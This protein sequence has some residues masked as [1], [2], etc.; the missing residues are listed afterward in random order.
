MN[1]VEEYEGSTGNKFDLVMRVRDDGFA[2][3]DWVL[4]ANY[5]HGFTTLDCQQWTGLHDMSY[6]MGRTFASDVLHSMIRWR[7]NSTLL[8]DNL[9]QE[10]RYPQN[11]ERW[12]LAVVTAFNMP[13]RKLSVCDIPMVTTRFVKGG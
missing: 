8:R 1:Q 7:T 5:A 6:V 12:L 4:D 13:I 11:P 10:E 9:P 2:M 3:A